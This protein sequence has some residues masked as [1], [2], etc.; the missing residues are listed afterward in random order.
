MN[1]FI[2]GAATTLGIDTAT[3]SDGFVNVS[4]IDPTNSTIVSLV[5]GIAAT[6]ILNILKSKFPK[7]FKPYKSKKTV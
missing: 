1:G 3:V 4:A 7:L 2:T 5:G 6:V